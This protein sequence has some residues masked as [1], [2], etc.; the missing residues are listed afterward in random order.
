MVRSARIGSTLLAAAL[1]LTLAACSSGDSSE[2]ATAA[3]STSEAAT[4]EAVAEETTEAAADEA[5]TEDT[6][7]QEPDGALASCIVGAWS[8]SEESLREQMNTLLGES[9]PADLE[10]TITGTSDI[11]FTEA[12]SR[13]APTTRSRSPWA[14][15]RPRSR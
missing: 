14:P 9:M 12:G 5:A 15:V 13:S 3:E 4:E 8:V 6:A 11:T 7:A 2:E 10:M 1:A